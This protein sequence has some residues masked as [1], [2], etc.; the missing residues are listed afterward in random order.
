[1]PLVR[2]FS[3][4]IVIQQQEVC[5]ISSVEKEIIIL[6]ARKRIGYFKPRYGINTAFLVWSD[7]WFCIYQ[8]IEK[9]K[10]QGRKTST[11]TSSMNKNLSTSNITEFC[12]NSTKGSREPSALFITNLTKGYQWCNRLTNFWR[13]LTFINWTSQVL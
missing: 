6:K 12:H 8:N 9:L 13:C 11:S 4:K 2:A 1:M 5:Y 3:M 10:R 7:F